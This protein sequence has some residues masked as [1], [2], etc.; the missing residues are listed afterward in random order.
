MTSIRGVKGAV[1]LGHLNVITGE[2]DEKCQDGQPTI[3]SL[4]LLLLSSLV[5]GRALRCPGKGWGGW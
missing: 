5:A 1:T 2:S 3:L 4:R